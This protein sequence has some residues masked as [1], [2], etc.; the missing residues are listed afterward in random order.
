MELIVLNIGLDLGVI[1]PKIFTMMVIMALVTTVIT[2][3]LL[4]WIAPREVLRAEAAERASS[5]NHAARLL[6]CVGDAG[7]GP[8]MARLAVS[9]VGGSG[10]SESH[11]LHL[12]R[13]RERTSSY[14]ARGGQEQGA[15]ASLLDTAAESGVTLS[16]N[17]FDSSDAARD[18]C[19]VANERD[20]DFV[21]LGL[22]RP[23]LGQNVFGGT[24]GAVLAEA[25]APVALLV[26]H[27]LGRAFAPH[28]LECRTVLALSGGARDARALD[29]AEQI[30]RDPRVSLTVL[31]L[32]SAALPARADALLGAYPERVTLRREP[33]PARHGALLDAAS[34]AALVILGLDPAWGLGL[35]GLQ[36]EGGRLVLS[37]PASLLFV[38]ERTSAR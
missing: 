35:D 26:D 29:L 28:A 4:E 31:C 25:P 32:E 16:S 17:Q 6:L 9:C 38:H 33:A 7:I 21:V 30:L 22:H 20:Y 24:V 10:R 5:A 11:A 1:S 19:R 8:A 36:S 34:R 18:I 27:G 13:P 3:P 23:V 12:H 14:L 37:S 2:T 15:L